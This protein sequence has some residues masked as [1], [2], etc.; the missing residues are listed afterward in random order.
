MRGVVMLAAMLFSGRD[1]V[2]SILPGALRRR[3]PSGDAF[4]RLRLTLSQFVGSAQLGKLVFGHLASPLH[5]DFVN[6]SSAI[7][8]R[9]FKSLARLA[10]LATCSCASSSRSRLVFFR[11][12]AY[13]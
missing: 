8:S 1:A 2:P 13:I 5:F 12:S 3:R 11:N 6:R 10:S 4:E 7:T 9:S